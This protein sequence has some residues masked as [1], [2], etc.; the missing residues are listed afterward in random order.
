[1]FKFKK[2]FLIFVASIFFMF[3]CSKEDIDYKT[4][5]EINGEIIYKLCQKEQI[6]TASTYL[7]YY[8]NGYPYS[9]YDEWNV[10]F[11]IDGQI[12]KVGDTYYNMNKLIKYEIELYQGTKVLLLYFEG[13]YDVYKN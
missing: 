1:M 13:F 8:Q 5:G 12:I 10:G 2:V 9:S 3:S 7:I 6:K 4:E 11:V